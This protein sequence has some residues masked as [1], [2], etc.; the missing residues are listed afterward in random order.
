M[1]ES[2][3]YRRSLAGR[4]L[5]IYAVTVVVVLG[6][7][8]FLVE[9]AARQTLLAELQEGVTQQ[10]L[11]LA[12]LVPA[13]DPQR[14]V[15]TAASDIDSR[16]TLISPDG[17]VAGDSLRDPETM[18]NHGGRPE[19]QAALRGEIGVDRRV[20]DTTG[21]GQLYVAVPTAEGSVLRIS[22]PENTVTTRIG[23]LRGGLF[24]IVGLAALI[25]VGVV[26]LV[27]RLLAR[28]L[29]HLSDVAG[30]IA[31]GDLDVEVPRSSVHELDNLARSIGTMATELGNRLSEVEDE[32]RT[33][34]VVLDSLPQG[35]LL[36]GSDDSVLY[37]NRSLGALLGPIP[38]RL[39][40]VV[41]FRIQE[42]V[43]RA[44]QTGHIVDSDLDHGR[45]MRILRVIVSPF[46][47]GRVLAVV[48]DITERSRLDDVRRDFVT[49]ASHEL[50]TPVATILA[51]AETLQIAIEKA[52]D[53][54]PQFAANIE[55]AAR[56]LSR[57]ISDLLD[58]SR[59]EGRTS[60]FVAVDLE[61]V[62]TEV[63]DELSGPA[64]ERQI[65][66]QME[67]TPVIINGSS[68]DI[69]LAIRNLVDNAIR[70]TDASGAVEVRLEKRGR[71]AVV[72]VVDTGAGIPRRDLDRVFERFY[73][74]DAARSRATGGTGLG[75][76]IV[77]HVAE[78]HGGRVS[79]ESRLGSGS[80]FTLRLPAFAS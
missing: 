35:T 47:D 75:L 67:T 69:S 7:I 48:G 56:S 79:V 38:E 54:V 1:S 6:A 50:K 68:S 18:E 77:R 64:E 17:S 29:H 72:T 51:S 31:A 15:D 37:G 16:V 32:R 22:L 40:K 19:V 59:L 60:E 53:R 46:D 12:P 43:R 23:T 74:V 21:F 71:E 80:T 20:S 14:F 76:S 62:V 49:N 2:A 30:A 45:P 66:L 5:L 33:L 63:V 9:R 26:A 27:A 10:A 39:D 34:G 58:L 4:L 11:A 28:P 65:S 55:Q 3:T 57:M 42:M 52:P 78:S 44:R 8:G 36:V 25:G 70:Y 61:A 13:D 73:R 41:P 24:A